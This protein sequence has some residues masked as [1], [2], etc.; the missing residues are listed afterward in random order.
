MPDDDPSTEPAVPDDPTPERTAAGRLRPGPP[1]DEPEVDWRAAEPEPPRREAGS[2]EQRAASRADDRLR[3]VLGIPALQ[4]TGWTLMILGGL[5]YL[6]GL[7]ATANA[8]VAD[9]A[10]P[11]QTITIGGVTFLQGSVGLAV[12]V[13]G[14]LLALLFTFVPVRREP[15]LVP[16]TLEFEVAAEQVTTSRDVRRM[17]MWSG[18]GIFLLGLV[19]AAWPLAQ[20]VATGEL[21][22]VTIGG[23]RYR[24][25]FW[26]YLIAA[27]GIALTVPMATTLGT[28]ER[29]AAVA[30]GALEGGRVRRVADRHT[31]DD[32]AREAHHGSDPDDAPLGPPAVPE[33]PERP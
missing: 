31:D 5:I 13:I 16:G 14:L 18:V 7:W 32:P 3:L 10:R 1:L 21:Y 4:A 26:G 27:F 12:A 23:E 11:E 24:L 6:H 17:L 8:V 20:T 22:R 2:L 19:L 33:D 30:E 25:H 29:A 28:M 15:R 9:A